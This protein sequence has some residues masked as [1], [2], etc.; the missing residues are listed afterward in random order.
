MNILEKVKTATR[1]RHDEMEA[2]AFS[3]KIAAQ[4]LS[5]Q[6]YKALILGH[7]VFHRETE[8]KLLKLTALQTLDELK[9]SERMKSGLLLADLQ[10]L[11][12]EPYLFSFQPGLQLSHP[13]QALGCMYVMEGATLGG[14]VIRR[15][16]VKIPEIAQSGALHYYGCYGD[17]TGSRWKQFKQVVEQ[18]VVSDEE[19]QQFLQSAD[20]TFE[21]YAACMKTAVQQLSAETIR[22]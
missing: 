19:Q 21:Q 6:E 11:Q 8:A 1:E 22:T 9:V 3:D 10:Q 17:Q 2:V 13:A 20:D 18:R 16:L 5:L 15:S 14:S 4:S 7:Y 12:L